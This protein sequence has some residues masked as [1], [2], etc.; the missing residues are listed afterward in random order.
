M[1]ISSIPLNI[2]IHPHAQTDL[3]QPVGGRGEEHGH[4][5][6]ADQGPHGSPVG[7]V[8]GG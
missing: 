3:H 1:S 5:V 8:G 2:I 7:E 6:T 4:V